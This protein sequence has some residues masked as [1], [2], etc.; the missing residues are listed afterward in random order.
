MLDSR[1]GRPNVHKVAVLGE[2]GTGKTTLCKTY[3]RQRAFLDSFQTIAVEFHVI[4]MSVQSNQPVSFRDHETSEIHILQIWDLAG[5]RHFKN[6]GVFDKYC[7]GV[8]GILACFDMTDIETLYAIPEWLSFVPENVHRILVG[9]KSDMT[10]F[11]DNETLHE[12]VESIM[13][14]CGFDQYIETSVTDVETV[15]AAFSALLARMTGVNMTKISVS[16][17]VPVKA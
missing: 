12:D 7:L 11:D 3:Q 5:Q 4:Q 2:G 17:Q 16:G 9:T 6:M 8:E 1:A 10:D 13:D 14:S 15:N